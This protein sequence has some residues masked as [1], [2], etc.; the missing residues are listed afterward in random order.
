MT[1]ISFQDYASKKQIAIKANVTQKI[2][3]AFTDDYMSN[4]VNNEVDLD[5]P[6]IAFD[7]ATIQF[8]MRGMAHRSQGESHPSQII[9]DK[10][11]SS[12]VG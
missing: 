4:L 9:L 7:I 2:L 10:L 6:D 3:T 12:I 1:V 5:N 11:K 8:L